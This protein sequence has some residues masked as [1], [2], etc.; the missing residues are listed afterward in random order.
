[1]S[2]RPALFIGRTNR[3]VTLALALA[4]VVLTLSACD[5]ES[6]SETVTPID[7]H[8]T[9]FDGTVGLDSV[10]VEPLAPIPF[11]N[12]QA[13]FDYLG[14]LDEVGMPVTSE[15][16]IDGYEDAFVA[17]GYDHCTDFGAAQSWMLYEWGAT[18]E[19]AALIGTAAVM[20]LCTS[21]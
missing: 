7:R 6:S 14:Y 3:F 17:L 16:F 5:A 15:S 10:F 20:F 19:F 8:V 12:D 21:E 18:T 11:G 4:V 9:N 2:I 1:M 13:E